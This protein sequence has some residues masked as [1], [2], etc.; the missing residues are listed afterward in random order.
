MEKTA[1]EGELQ[2]KREELQ[3]WYEWYEEKDE[4]E[5]DEEEDKEEE[6]FSEDPF[7]TVTGP[8]VGPS[9]GALTSLKSAKTHSPSAEP[10]PSACTQPVFDV[11]ADDG[12]GS[13]GFGHHSHPRGKRATEGIGKG[14]V[15]GE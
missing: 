10:T 8:S 7:L 5:D 14:G 4:E 9:L 12:G 3:E 6:G 13:V 11:G 1:L 15:G 2:D